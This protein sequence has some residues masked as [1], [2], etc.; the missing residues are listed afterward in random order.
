MRGDPGAKGGGSGPRQRSAAGYEAWLLS[1]ALSLGLSQLSIQGYGRSIHGFGPLSLGARIFPVGSNQV[2]RVQ[3]FGKMIQ[4][5]LTSFWLL[6]NFQVRAAR[7]QN[8]HDFNMFFLMQ[9]CGLFQP[10][11]CSRFAFPSEISGHAAPWLCGTFPVGQSIMVV[12]GYRIPNRKHEAQALFRRPARL[13][14]QYSP[15]FARGGRPHRRF[16]LVRDRG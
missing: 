16:V 6:V 7:W 3:N 15:R 8:Q 12:A 5:G 2:G 11:S 1:G 10:L 4:R 14:I 9:P 13:S